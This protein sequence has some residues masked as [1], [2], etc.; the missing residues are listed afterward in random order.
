M[1]GRW[2]GFRNDAEREA[3]WVL[4]EV[5]R[6]DRLALHDLRVIDEMHPH[7][8][9]HAVGSFPDCVTTTLMHVIAFLKP[10]AGE[11]HER[12]TTIV[13]LNLYSLFE[14]DW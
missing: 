4:E 6:L 9:Y 5:R 14:G 8:P 2:P 7:D 3:A 1:I 12:H 11:T 13:A 10:L